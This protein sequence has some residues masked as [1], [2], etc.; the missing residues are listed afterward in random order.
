M[1]TLKQSRVI[2]IKDDGTLV[3]GNPLATIIACFLNLNDPEE[4]I[5]IQNYYPENGSKNDA[6]WVLILSYWLEERGYDWGVLKDHLY[7]NE[8]YIVY[9]EDRYGMTHACIYKNGA[10]WHDPH[11]DGEG[12]ITEGQFEYIK[13]IKK[14]N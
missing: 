12:L 1:K 9:G 6:S 13:K 5:Q 10:L 8:P 11:P 3:R 14:L 2:E 4:A 7:D